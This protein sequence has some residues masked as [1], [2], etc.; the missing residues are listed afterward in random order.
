MSLYDDLLL[1]KGATEGQIKENY[2]KLAKQYHP[3]AAGK[4]FDKAKWEKI[5]HAY[6]V[7]SDPEKRK[8]YDETGDDQ[9]KNHE[10]LED[11][12]VNVLIEGINAATNHVITQG[13]HE[14]DLVKSMNN[15]IEKK[16]TATLDD[17]EQMKKALRQLWL[18]RRKFIK[19][20]GRTAVMISVVK[21][22]INQIRS[23]KQH[24]EKFLTILDKASELMLLVEFEYEPEEIEQFLSVGSASASRPAFFQTNPWT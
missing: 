24:A 19:T 7:L 5:L 4:N 9:S 23:Q 15:H 21:E 8:I 18:F 11:L 1:R 2:R 12:A 6:E 3:D 14:F 16:R 17:I 10:S 22:K 13:E 20:E